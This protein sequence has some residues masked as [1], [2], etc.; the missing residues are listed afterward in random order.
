[1]LFIAFGPSGW[2]DGGIG[3]YNL[4]HDNR[5]EPAGEGRE[6]QG[7]QREE[8]EGHE[9]EKREKGEGEGRGLHATKLVQT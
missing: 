3:K 8:E 1:M 7:G 5:Y 9:R 2:H 4:S 6:R